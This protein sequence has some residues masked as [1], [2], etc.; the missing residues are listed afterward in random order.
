[1]IQIDDGGQY[2]Y[3]KGQ[4]SV[5]DVLLGY[6]QSCNCNLE[7]M[8]RFI[9]QIKRSQIEMVSRIQENKLRKIMGNPKFWK[10][11]D[12]EYVDTV[13][14]LQAEAFTKELNARS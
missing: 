9:E 5:C 14:K 8:I 10:E 13:E 6:A 11:Q 7:E 2:A 1:M 4:I 3:A 12:P